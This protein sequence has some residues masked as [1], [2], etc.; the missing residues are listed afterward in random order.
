MANIPIIGK[1]E[2][3]PYPINMFFSQAAHKDLNLPGLMGTPGLKEY[4]DPSHAYPVRGLHVMGDNLYAV[5]GNRT[6][7]I[8]STPIGT[9]LGGTLAGDKAPVFMENDGTN[10]MLV[11][12]GVEGYSFDVGG[13]VTAIIDI[14]FP[15]PSGLAWQDGYFIVVEADSDTF[16][17]SSLYD[18]T[19]WDANDYTTAESS[20]DIT[21]AIISHH[22]ELIHFGTK[23]IE[24]YYNSGNSTFPFETIQGAPIQEGIG[25]AHSVAAGDNSVFFLDVHGRV[26]QIRGHSSKVIS[27]RSIEAEI[28]S[29]TRFDDAIGFYYAQEGHGFYVLSFPKGDATWVF[30]VSVQ[31][32][33]KRESYPVLLNGRSSRWRANCH[34]FFDGKHIVGD[35]AN[36]KLYELDFETYKDNSETILRV[37]DFPVIG[38]GKTRI[39]H[40]KLKIDY[41]TGVGLVAGV[42]SDP[43]ALLRW[44][45]DGGHT[46]S[47][48]LQAS[49]GKIGEHDKEVNFRRLGASTHRIYR[50]VVSDPVEPVVTGAKLT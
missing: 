36:G 14:D 31:F 1:P 34:A 38:D 7:K 42:G 30:D 43:M 4:Y 45:D 35:Y 29:F 22:K 10:I 9:L 47:N 6:Y 25:A 26:T 20:P 19:P 13:P 16:Y 40:N 41:K 46:W 15:V 18:P 11:E 32:P 24:F 8:N 48:L 44:S 5:I 3:G 27:S 37:F 33:H 12:P 49:M 21:L 50:N 17:I 2:L 39:R 23:T 28:C